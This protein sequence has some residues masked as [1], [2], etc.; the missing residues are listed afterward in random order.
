MNIA[1]KQTIMALLRLL[2]KKNSV[3]P[4]DTIRIR[5]YYF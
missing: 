5:K 4:N 1:M 3:S 2:M